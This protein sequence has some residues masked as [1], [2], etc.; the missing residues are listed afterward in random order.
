[1]RAAA[2]F[3]AP[4]AAFDVAI[5]FLD[6]ALRH[7]QP[8][9]IEATGDAGQQ[10]VEIVGEAARQLADSLH[11]LGLAELFLG[12][13]QGLGL[14]P[15]RRDVAADRMDPIIRRRGVPGDP[16]VGPILSPVA[17]FEQRDDGSIG[18][19]LRSVDRPLEI[20][21]VDQVE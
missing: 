21:R 2:R 12:V 19:D 3:A 7:P 10:V 15:F 20:V 17:I 13:G 6:A 11:L 5:E 1:M 8:E 18:D 4:W 14:F 9:E 16:A